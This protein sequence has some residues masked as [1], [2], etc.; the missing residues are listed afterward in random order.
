MIKFLFSLII[1]LS[2]CLNSLGQNNKVYGKVKYEWKKTKPH[3]GVVLSEL[4]FDEN[5]SLFE[6]QNK[7]STDQQETDN[8]THFYLN[9]KDNLDHWIFKNSKERVIYL[10]LFINDNNYLVK[11]DQLELDW[12]LED[13]YRTIHNFKCQKATTTYQN[14]KI[15]AWFSEELAIPYGPHIW[16]GLPGLV[17]EVYDDKYVNHFIATNLEINQNPSQAFD[18]LNT[19]D[20]SKFITVSEYDKIVDS[21]IE[22]LENKLNSRRG[23]NE[24][25]IRFDDCEDCN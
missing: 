22:E 25:P 18:K 13:E 17:L 1:S 20:I 6:W 7:K 2:F 16:T 11:N 19:I 3:V 4:I 15:T 21:S 12:D 9:S 8:T 24:K 23:V 5:N 10:N 14:R